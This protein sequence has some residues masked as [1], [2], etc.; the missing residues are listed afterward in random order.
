MFW[1][2]CY[3][4]AGRLSGIQV[5]RIGCSIETVGLTLSLPFTTERKSVHACWP[6][7]LVALACDL[8]TCEQKAE[9]GSRGDL[10][11]A[12][13]PPDMRVRVRRFLALPKDEA[14]LF[15]CHDDRHP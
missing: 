7:L 13:T 15:L 5:D 2:P 6:G 10:P 9:S 14:A 3:G 12:P 11:P 8:R 4:S 1:L